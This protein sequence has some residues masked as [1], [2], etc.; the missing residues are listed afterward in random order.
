MASPL[1][2]QLPGLTVIARYVTIGLG[3]AGEFFVRVV[4]VE[5]LAGTIGNVGEKTALRDG[6]A[7]IHVAGR[8]LARLDRVEKLSHMA[9]GFWNGRGRRFEVVLLLAFHVDLIP[10]V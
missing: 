3:V 9:G 10:V 2:L 8:G 7:V 6:E 4:P 1:T 5:P